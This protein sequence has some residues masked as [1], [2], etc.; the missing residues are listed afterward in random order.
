[1]FASAEQLL[2]EY[3]SLRRYFASGFQY[4]PERDAPKFGMVC[5]ESANQRLFVEPES[6]YFRVGRNVRH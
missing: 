5:L 1:M 3:P 4:R 2:R 6:G